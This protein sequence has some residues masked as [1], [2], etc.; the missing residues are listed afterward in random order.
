M[1]R[2]INKGNN[3]F[4]DIVNSEYVDKTSLIPFI[5]STLNT[6]RRYSCVTRCRRF[7]KS[8]A[9]KMLCAYY[10][11]SCD[12]WELFRGLEA[13]K[14]KSFEKFLNKYYVISIDMTDFTTKYRGEREI[15]RLIQHEIMDDV[16]EVF[17]DTKI[18]ERDDLMDI[19]Y[20]INES[21]GDRFVMIIDEWDAILREMGT[22]E[23][24]TTS[25]V[26]LLR[27]LFKGSGSNEVFA[28][29]YLTGILPIKKYNTESALNN[30]REYSMI[31]PGRIATSLGFTHAEV[32]S[33]CR[34]YGMDIREMERWYDGYSIGDE[35]HI[36]N[37]YSVMRAIEDNSYR[38][39]WTTTGAY[40]SVITYIQM[41]FDGLKDDVIRMLAGEHVDVDTTEFLNDMHIVRSKNDVLTVLIHLGYL[42]YDHDN[43]ECYIPNKE[44]ADEMNNAIKATSWEPLIKT[45]QNSKN[46][47]SATIS[48]NEQAVAQ[49]I[50]IAH[51][52]HTSI[53]SYNDENSLACVLSVAYIWAK[54][55]YVIHREYATGK[56]YADL[57]MIPRLNVS[58][59]A[60]VIEL[61]NERGGSRRSQLKFNHS[62]DTAIDQ[63]MRKEY[64][65]KLAE[66]TGEILLVGI[67]Y[68]KDTKQH[69]CKIIHVEQWE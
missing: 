46:L 26:D 16:V 32:E 69:T 43:Q 49:A 22:D 4:R 45:I 24:I 12:S 25:Y 56:G 59:P 44:V 52:E 47:L 63:I 42:A 55:E 6:E 30:F 66:Y 14:D 65:A 68:N 3:A 28:G 29:A 2:Y 62:A 15:V 5:N 35:S 7:G 27:R 39:Y 34:Q 18:K 51:D 21:T 50:D 40:D 8:M 60:L 54:N 38:S 37:P 9:A 33:L 41:N 58:K 13:E 23:Y 17:P 1:G 48:G 20:S 31:Y 36:Y 19:L 11:K 67:N 57:V 10:D 61:T 53:L 64:P